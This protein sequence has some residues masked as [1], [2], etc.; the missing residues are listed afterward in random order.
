M[1]ALE[2]APAFAVSAATAR[3][4]ASTGSRA[5]YS[6]DRPAAETRTSFSTRVGNATASSAP[7]KPPIELPTTTGQSSPSSAHSRSVVRANAGID[8]SGAS[9]D[10]PKPGRSNATTRC[11][12]MNAGRLSSQFCQIPPRPWMNSSGGLSP[13]LSTTWTLWPSMTTSLD[14]DGQSMLIHVLSS[15]SA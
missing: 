11:V 8:S 15:P 3:P 1:T 7:T 12:S 14:S 9:S 4:M 10:C 2:P 13:P 6:V 5:T